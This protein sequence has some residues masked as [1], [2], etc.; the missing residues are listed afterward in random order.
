MTPS[1]LDPVVSVIIP[2]YNGQRFLSETLES[3]ISQTMTGWEIIAINDESTDNSR[4]VLKLYTERYPD[5]IRCIS[6]RNGGVSRAR[7][8]GVSLARGKYIAFLD[9]DD[10]WMPEKLQLQT[11]LLS[12]DETL[13]MVF[14]NEALIDE[15]GSVTRE[16][17]ITFGAAQHGAIFE[18]LLFDNFIPI[19]SVLVKKDLFLKA[20]GF[21]PR[22]SLAEDYDLLL[23][24]VR[25]TRVDY[26]DMPL[27]RYREHRESG[28][29]TKIDR[30]I[31]EALEII[32][33]WK[34][35][36]PA[37]FRKHYFQYLK[38]RLNFS[39][40]K[41]KIVLKNLNEKDS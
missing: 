1:V 20:G 21:D 18:S 41:M 17:A 35:H 39:L 8:T 34:E 16:K 30:I 37:L 25:E 11:E 31:A 15:T 2:V 5:K 12:S 24:I 33:Y 4:K 23:K 26:I 13:G 7:N 29:H 38:F 10:L 19:S 40:L 22:F 3:V 32:G 6:V 27:L 28:T 9:Q 36:D 14:T